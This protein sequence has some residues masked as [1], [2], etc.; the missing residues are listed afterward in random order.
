MSITRVQ[1]NSVNST[2]TTTSQ[3]VTLGAGV[4]QGN[5]LVAAVATGNNATTL[6]GPTGWTQGTINQPAG[7]TATIETSIWNLVVAAA[8]AGH[9]S[10]TWTL[11]ASHTVYICIEERNATLGCPSNPVDVS[12]NGATVG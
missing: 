1:G 5:L 10:W 11:S 9:T 3:A 8:N 6:T 12:A 4:T 7:S 2:G